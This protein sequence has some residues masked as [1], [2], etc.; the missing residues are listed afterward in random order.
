MTYSLAEV[1]D[2]VAQFRADLHDIQR[3]MDPLVEQYERM[4]R[5]DTN[6]DERLHKAL[7]MV[8]SAWWDIT[9]TVGYLRAAD[10]RLRDGDGIPADAET[11]R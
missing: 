8:W 11:E 7:A 10:R 9:E 3:R 4:T 2:A 6:E 5:I 1:E